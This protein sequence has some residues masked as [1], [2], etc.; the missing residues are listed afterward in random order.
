MNAIRR[1]VHILRKYI[2]MTNVRIYAIFYRNWGITYINVN[3]DG[4]SFVTIVK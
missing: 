1:G 2:Q 4:I 3:H